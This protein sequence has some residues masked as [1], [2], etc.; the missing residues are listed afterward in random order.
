MIF[1]ASLYTFFISVFHMTKDGRVKLIL[2]NMT[3]NVVDPFYLRNSYWML[4]ADIGQIVYVLVSKHVDMFTL[5]YFLL[6]EQ[7]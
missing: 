3:K 6:S 7:M 5:D 4:P 2:V 1:A